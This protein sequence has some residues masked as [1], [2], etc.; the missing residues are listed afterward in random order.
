MVFYCI[1]LKCER[2]GNRAISRRRVSR[3]LHRGPA[4]MAENL[5]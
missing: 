3:L 4:R 5:A 2:R 1:R